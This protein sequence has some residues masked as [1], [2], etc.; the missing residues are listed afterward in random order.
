[1][2]GILHTAIGSALSKL[3]SKHLIVLSH[4]E[5]ISKS[6]AVNMFFLFILLC[7]SVLYLFF[8]TIL[9]TICIYL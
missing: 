7:L 6:M 8:F 5:H 4:P 3:S 1:M 2:T 9:G